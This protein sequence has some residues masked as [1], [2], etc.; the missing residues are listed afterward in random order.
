MHL[1]STFQLSPEDTAKAETLGMEIL[2][3]KNQNELKEWKDTKVLAE[4]DAV[5]ANQRT[6]QPDFLEKCTNLK[7]AHVPH[8]GIEHLPLDYLESRKIVLTNARGVA[9]PPISEDILCKMLALARKY[10]VIARQQQERRWNFPGSISELSG[11]TAGILGTGNIGTE[12][13]AKA[14]V[15]GM[16]TLGLN[17]TGDSVHFFDEVYVTSEINQLILQSDFIICTIPLTKDTHHLISREQLELMKPTAFII[18]I[19]RGNLFDE[20]VLLEFL[21]DRRIAGAALD[22]FADELIYGCLPKESPFWTLDNVIITPHMAGAG[23]REWERNA[24]IIMTNI[25]AV[26]TDDKNKMLNI[27]NYR[28]G[29]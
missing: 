4:A 2:Y 25:E 21:S 20:A 9:G 8:V 12:T 1:L 3:F 23:D 29:Y 5:I 6:L 18:N 27:R 28:K 24:A 15:F 13:A 26:C 19:S 22:V 17:T 16:K 10:N 11:K 14:K 7:W